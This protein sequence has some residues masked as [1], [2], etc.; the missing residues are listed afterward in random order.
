[1]PMTGAQCLGGRK[2]KVQ[3]PRDPSLGRKKR[4]SR[5]KSLDEAQTESKIKRGRKGLE[6]SESIKIRCTQ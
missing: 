5:R 6:L 3:C 1:M 2:S 4:G